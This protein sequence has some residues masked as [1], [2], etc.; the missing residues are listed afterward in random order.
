MLWRTTL[1]FVRRT[2]L[3][4][5][6]NKITNLIQI[7]LIFRHQNYCISLS[8]GTKNGNLGGTLDLRQILY[9][10]R[11][12]MTY[13]WYLLPAHQ[14]DLH[15]VFEI[16]CNHMRFNW[17]KLSTQGIANVIDRALAIHKID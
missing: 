6:N 13:A 14:S 11:K 2:E 10:K 12:V 3:R 5:H 15:Q 4:F 17:T 16:L 7:L 1:R 8:N 9:I